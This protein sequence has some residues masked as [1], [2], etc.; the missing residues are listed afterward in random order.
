M[1]IIF[2]RNDLLTVNVLIVFTILMRMAYFYHLP[3]AEEL[4]F[5]YKSNFFIWYGLKNFYIQQPNFFWILST[6]FW[7]LVALYFKY[8]MIKHKLVAQ[9]NFIPAMSFLLIGSAVPQYAIFSLQAISALFVF[10][11]IM[12]LLSQAQSKNAIG[13]LFFSGMFLGCG[14]FLYWHNIIFLIPAT[15]ILINTRLTSSKEFVALLLGCALPFYLF[16]TLHYVIGNYKIYNPFLIFPLQLPKL[17]YHIYVPILLTTI[18]VVVVF[19]GIFLAKT[20]RSYA[21]IQ[22]TKNWNSVLQYFLFSLLAVVFTS[23]F[24]N[25]AW[26]LMLFP[27]SIILSSSFINNTKKYNTFTFYLILLSVL[28]LQWVIRFM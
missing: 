16:F 13:A 15:L 26:T 4:G 22:F 2:K 6:L 11:S 3:S 21:L 8:E 10:I 5:F 27:F 28:A 20:Q 18:G 12:H 9:K 1:L 25:A 23:I 24:P 14:I 17:L 7:L 19:Y